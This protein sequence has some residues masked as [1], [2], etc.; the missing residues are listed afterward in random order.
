MKNPEVENLVLLSFKV[1]IQQAWL[2]PS[3][4]LMNSEIATVQVIIQPISILEMRMSE[5]TP[6]LGELKV[7]CLNRPDFGKVPPEV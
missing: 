2:L 1:D 6:V 5:N 3:F 7:V 4:K